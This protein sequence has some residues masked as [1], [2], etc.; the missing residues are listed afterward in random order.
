MRSLARNH[1]V[2]AEAENPEYAVRVWLFGALS[3]LS[4]ERPMTLLF[5]AGCTSREVIE[6]MGER[7]G[8]ALLDQVLEEGG[9]LLGCCRVFANGLAVEDLD[10]PLTGAGSAMDVEM[11]LLM[12]YEGG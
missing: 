4:P 10:A 7:C 5:P 2:N 11:I 12:G 1:D 8:P 3:A 9:S 6:A